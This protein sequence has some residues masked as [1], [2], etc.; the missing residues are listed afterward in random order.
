MAGRRWISRAAEPNLFR[1]TAT[2]LRER[3]IARMTSSSKEVEQS[4][5]PRRCTFIRHC[6][7]ERPHPARGMVPPRQAYEP[8][9]KDAPKVADT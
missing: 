3:H 1:F 8:L 4:P 2:E 7:E 6:N 5:I 9:D